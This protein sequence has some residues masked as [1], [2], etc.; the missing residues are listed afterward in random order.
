M[1]VVLFFKLPIHPPLVGVLDPTTLRPSEEGTTSAPE[2]VDVHAQAVGASLMMRSSI[3][4]LF[5]VWLSHL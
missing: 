4:F 3:R 1:F 2:A 5:L